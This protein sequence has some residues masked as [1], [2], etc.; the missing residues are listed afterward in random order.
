MFPRGFLEDCAG[1]A[2]APGCRGDNKSAHLTRPPRPAPPEGATPASSAAAAVAHTA[3]PAAPQPG[4]YAISFCFR[5][6][7]T[8]VFLFY[9]CLHGA[10][11]GSLPCPR[12]L[13]AAMHGEPLPILIRRQAPRGSA[14]GGA[15]R[16]R[17][18]AG[19][20]VTLAALAALALRWRTATMPPPV[21]KCL[22]A[23]TTRLPRAAR[24]SQ[25]PLACAFGL[26]L[27]PGLVLSC[28]R[29][30]RCAGLQGGAIRGSC[31]HAAARR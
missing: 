6:L 19:Q 27:R 30:P 24:G 29:R 14:G 31:S 26:C 20:V 9:F 4:I 8:L 17:W 13:D 5:A 2:A 23:M 1:V 18:H 12:R 22:A 21:T 28:K 3:A 10:R 16:G 11:G 7:P 25:R 15:G